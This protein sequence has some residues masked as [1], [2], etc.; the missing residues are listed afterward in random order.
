MTLNTAS[1]TQ[2]PYNSCFRQRCH[3]LDP[4]YFHPIRLADRIFFHIDGLFSLSLFA[5]SVIVTQLSKVRY[6]PPS[7]FPLSAKCVS[8][9]GLYNTKVNFRFL[10]FCGSFE[11]WEKCRCYQHDWPVHWLDNCHEP[12]DKPELNPL[13]QLPELLPENSMSHALNVPLRSHRSWKNVFLVL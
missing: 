12:L 8:Y 7:F 10:D 6:E 2:S 5:K 3:R 1:V 9:T 11:Q 4:E 13:I